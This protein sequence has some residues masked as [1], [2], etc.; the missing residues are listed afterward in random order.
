MANTEQLMQY[1][2]LEATKHPWTLSKPLKHKIITVDPTRGTWKFDAADGLDQGAV[3]NGLPGIA[4][5]AKAQIPKS[6]PEPLAPS[7]LDI[8]VTGQCWLLIRLDPIILNWQFAKKKV[9]VTLK[10][11][12]LQGDNIHLR[13]VYANDPVDHPGHEG[14][15]EN[16]GCKAVFFGVVSRKQ[17]NGTQPIDLGSCYINLN[18]EFLQTVDGVE[19]RLQLIIDPDVPNDGGNGAFPP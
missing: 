15:V 3:L 17:N 18:V 7:P 11:E 9:P 13:H 14:V 2:I 16:D 19:K 12:D 10:H 5:Y 4:G 8:P 1:R 6:R